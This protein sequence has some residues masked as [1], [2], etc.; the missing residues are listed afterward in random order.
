MPEYLE[1]QVEEREG[2]RYYRLAGVA[3]EVESGA[4]IQGVFTRQGGVSQGPWRSLNVGRSVGDDPWAVEIN[5]RRI[6]RALGIGRD[7]V[8][9]AQQVHG[10]RVARVKPRD[11]GSTFPATDGLITDAADVVLLL[12]F[13]D[14]VPLLFFDPH[15]PAV[16][17]AHAG[18][19]GTLAR[20]A[21]RMVKAMEAA[22]DS[23]P[24]ELIV[25]IGPAIGPCCYQ[26][27]DELVEQVWE[28]FPEWPDLIQWRPTSG[29]AQ[30]ADA[31]GARPY[32]DLWGANRRQ[33]EA[34]G[35][36]SIA[37]ARYCTA[38]HVDEFFS[39]RAACLGNHEASR[40]PRSSQEKGQTG[41]FATVIG[42][43]GK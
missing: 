25:G 37:V 3:Q 22:F 2:L 7:A 40:W 36:R 33:L 10:T 5:H 32:F 24:E 41:R 26:V 14:C 19:R 17:L 30:G 12:R 1:W 28:Q 35:V 11:R 27:G 38:C 18:W 6:Y 39:Y 4:L 15:C 42:L 8:T 29:A 9:S 43:R 31:S 21:G 16:G 34:L 20:I 23:H 13:A